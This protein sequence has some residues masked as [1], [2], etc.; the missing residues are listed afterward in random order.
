LKF[1]LIFSRLSPKKIEKR[2]NGKKGNGASKCPKEE[3]D[4][5]HRGERG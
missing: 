3:R 2:T 4:E 1:Y 5:K